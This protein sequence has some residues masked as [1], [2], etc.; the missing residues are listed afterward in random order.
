MSVNF[1]AYQFIYLRARSQI[2]REKKDLRERSLGGQ[3]PPPFIF[4]YIFHV[5]A[6]FILYSTGK[7]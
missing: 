4:P 7:K 5:S 3:L 6:S 2:K 1:N